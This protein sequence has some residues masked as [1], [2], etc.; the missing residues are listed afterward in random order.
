MIN[1]YIY[2]TS[3]TIR[4]DLSNYSQVARCQ[5]S[6]IDDRQRRN[7]QSTHWAGCCF[8]RRMGERVRSEVLPSDGAGAFSW[9]KIWVFFCWHALSWFPI[10]YVPWLVD[11]LL[12]ENW[13]AWMKSAEYLVS[14]FREL[15]KRR[16]IKVISA[17]DNDSKSYCTCFFDISSQVQGVRLF[18]G[19][20]QSL[21]HLQPCE[22]P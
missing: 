16:W 13:N 8:F 19:V 15:A 22:T 10:W 21:K 20:V 17:P 9:N 18:W 11:L 4:Y 1:L 6:Y 5:K 3:I 12:G 7:C 14:I 2:C